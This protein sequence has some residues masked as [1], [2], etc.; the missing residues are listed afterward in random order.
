[1]WNQSKSKCRSCVYRAK[2]GA[3]NGC[4]YIHITGRMR[5]CPVKDCDKYEKGK[6]KNATHDWLQGATL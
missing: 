5:G 6:R 2:A 1:M 3:P 4:D